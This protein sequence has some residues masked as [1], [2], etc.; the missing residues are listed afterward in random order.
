MSW[1]AL[2]YAHWI[3][4]YDN[5]IQPHNALLN[6]WG[7]TI[8]HLLLLQH[9]FKK[10]LLV[11]K[12]LIFV[13]LAIAQF[14]KDIWKWLMSKWNIAQHDGNSTNGFFFWRWKISPLGDQKKSN[15]TCTKVF[16]GEN[17]HPLVTKRNLINLM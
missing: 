12:L 8:N 15:G 1:Q 16:L 7:Y 4:T 11:L 5:R 3:T 10:K 6:P 17:F 14:C 2:L 13:A 9:F